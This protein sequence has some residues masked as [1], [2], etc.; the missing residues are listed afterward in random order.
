L[1]GAAVLLALFTVLSLALFLF[2]A[3]V[4]FSLTSGF[5]IFLFLFPGAL[6]F[7][8]HFLA[9]RIG[10]TRTASVLYGLIAGYAGYI[11]FS[12][13]IIVFGHQTDPLGWAFPMLALVAV[14]IFKA[15]AIFRRLGFEN[16]AASAASLPLVVPESVFG[17]KD[18]GNSKDEGTDRVRSGE[19]D[20]G[21]KN[22]KTAEQKDEKTAAPESLTEEHVIHLG[23]QKGKEKT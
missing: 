11:A 5:W 1:F 17:V 3:N 4:E 8:I 14:L 23:P 18:V 15:N 7:S 10:A 9:S 13:A 22:K 6:V 12:L 19:R 2:L 21:E 16:A 20:R